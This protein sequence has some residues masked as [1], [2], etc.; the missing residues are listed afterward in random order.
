MV[1]KT[2]GT[3]SKT[4]VTWGENIAP[5][6]LKVRAMERLPKKSPEIF[7]FLET[8]LFKVLI[9]CCFP[10]FRFYTSTFIL[11]S[12]GTIPNHPSP[13]CPNSQEGTLQFGSYS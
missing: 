7:I 8:H 2:S 1:A 10:H 5:E 11:F 9:L 6:I 3:N 13:P 12:L 4:K